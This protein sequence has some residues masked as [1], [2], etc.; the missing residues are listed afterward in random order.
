MVT[1]LNV[2]LIIIIIRLFVVAYVM[3]TFLTYCRVHFINILISEYSDLIKF[4][5]NNMFFQLFG[6]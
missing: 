1:I 3:V 5:V 4:H 6:I 2:P